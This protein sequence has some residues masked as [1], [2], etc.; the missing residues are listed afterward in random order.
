MGLRLSQTQKPG[1]TKYQGVYGLIMVSRTHLI[2]AAGS[3]DRAPVPLQG[4]ISRL[5][6]NGR[7]RLVDQ[8]NPALRDLYVIRRW[9]H[10]IEHIL[11]VVLIAVLLVLPAS[12]KNNMSMGLGS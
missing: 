1:V 5:R 2:T 4:Q 11:L 7:S 6:F 10:T 12:T 8:L 3:G 9:W